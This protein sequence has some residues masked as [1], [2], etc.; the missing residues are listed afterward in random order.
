ME[1][2][3]YVKSIGFRM[4]PDN[5]L[6]IRGLVTNRAQFTVPRIRLFISLHDAS[7]NVIGRAA[8]EL[9]AVGPCETVAFESGTR[10]RDMAFFTVQFRLEKLHDVDYSDFDFALHK[11]GS[12]R[13]TGGDSQ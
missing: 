2:P 11:W 6:D 1:T 4:E 5:R 13:K 10:L 3:L 12:E 7:R 8:P 9:P